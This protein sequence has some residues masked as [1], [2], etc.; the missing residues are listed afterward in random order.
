MTETHALTTQ[1]QALVE[2][3]LAAVAERR[4]RADAEV[5]K[6]WSAEQYGSADI[7]E[8]AAVQI[9]QAIQRLTQGLGD[10][11]DW[12][13]M[14]ENWL[15]LSKQ[16]RALADADDNRLTVAYR[17]AGSET[18]QNVVNEIRALLKETN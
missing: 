4:S 13:H 7:L 15:S 10:T 3:W 1:L 12:K 11:V 14:T 6:V 17:R 16:M 9:Q 5:N 18:Y 8:E 2:K